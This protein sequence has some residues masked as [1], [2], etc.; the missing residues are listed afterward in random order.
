MDYSDSREQV[1]IWQRSKEEIQP[2]T[3]GLPGLAANALAQSALFGALARTAQGTK[4]SILLNLQEDGLFCARCLKGICRMVTG[5]PL[6]PASVPISADNP[7]AALRRC[8]GQ[9]LKA[10]A[11]YEGRAFHPEY[12][13]VFG[14]LA[15]KMR[16]HCCKI[17]QLLG[18]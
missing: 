6:Q 10:L 9:S 17:A 11:V 12:G 1:K 15:G 8:Y 16:E 5:Q 14:C 7:D 4:R 3:D 13:P 18:L 2:V